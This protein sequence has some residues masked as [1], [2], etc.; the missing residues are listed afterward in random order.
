VSVCNLCSNDSGVVERERRRIAELAYRLE[1]AKVDLSALASGN[2]LPHG[3]VAKDLGKRL[4]RLGIDLL[5]EW[6]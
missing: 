3:G 6:A 4:A 5:K 1:L 2:I